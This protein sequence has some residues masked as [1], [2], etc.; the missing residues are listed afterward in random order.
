MHSYITNKKYTVK[1]KKLKNSVQGNWIK[2]V[3]KSNTLFLENLRFAGTNCILEY[4][5][6]AN[7]ANKG[8]IGRI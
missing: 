1:I 3:K 7:C 6:D 8:C 2:H 5:M 4:L